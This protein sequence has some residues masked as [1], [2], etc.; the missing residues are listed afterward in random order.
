[1]SWARRLALPVVAAA[2]LA[3]AAP[4]AFADGDPASD[5][6]ITQQVFAP[7][8]GPHATEL[9]QLIAESKARGLPVRVALIENQADLGAILVL[10]HRPTSYA[11]FLGQELLR[12]Y[13]GPLLIVMPNGYGFYHGGKPTARQQAA[14]AK[15]PLPRASG[16]EALA[17]ASG[18]RALAALQGIRLVTPTPV[19][20]GPSRNHDRLLIGGAVGAALLVALSIFVIRRR[21]LAPPQR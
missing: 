15:L 10:W 18:V 2:C 6:L 1:M 13:R 5:Y 4:A 8:G 20:T 9:R 14:L 12:W 21:W 7:Y 3:A 17:A 16:D 19:S 11:K